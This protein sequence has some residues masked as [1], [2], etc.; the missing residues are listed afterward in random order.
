MQEIEFMKVKPLGGSFY[1]G[2]HGEGKGSLSE[3][4]ECWRD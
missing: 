1:V 3:S 4:K 2:L